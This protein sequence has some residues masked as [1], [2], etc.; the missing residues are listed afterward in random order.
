MFES[1]G[2]IDFDKNK[3]LEFIDASIHLFIYSSIHLFIYS[4]NI[5]DMILKLKIVLK[6]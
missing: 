2:L 1:E 6:L 5:L 4:I 3:T